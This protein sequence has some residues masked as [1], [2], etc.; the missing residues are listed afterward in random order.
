[1]TSLRIFFN[2]LLVTVLVFVVGILLGPRLQQRPPLPLAIPHG[3]V[4]HFVEPTSTA[5][6]I[7]S[8]SQDDMLDAE[9][10]SSFVAPPHAQPLKGVDLDGRLHRLGETD[11]CRASVVVFLGTECPI[12]KSV[13]PRVSRLAAE[14]QA[15]HVEFYGV[16]S[17]PSLSHQSAVEFAREYSISF[18]LL[19]DV[20]GELKE[21]LQATHTPHAFVLSPVGELLYRGA[22]DDQFVSA[23]GRRRDEPRSQWL[24]DA[25]QAVTHQQPIVIAETEP[26]GCLLEPFRDQP[27]TY[28]REIAPI[29]LRQCA[30][31]HQPGAVAPFSLLTYDDVRRH[32]A[33][34]RVMVDLKQMPPWRPLR[35][36]G[37]FRNELSLSDREI[38]LLTR[39][40]DAGLPEGDRSQQWVTA[41]KETREAN[42]SANNSTSDVAEV[43]AS[44]WLLGQ[45]DLIL[46][47]PEPFAV[48]ADGP[49]IYQYFVVPTK[50]NADR[51]VS[52]I[53]Y[54]SSNTRVVHHASFRFDDAGRARQLDLEQ[55]GLGYQRF[56]GWG[57]ETGGTLGGWA[58]GN[59]P[60][61][62]PAGF[63]RPI[64]A[65]SDF[66]LQTHYHPTGRAE[67]EQATLGVHFAPASSTRHIGEL[68]V[69]NQQL[70]IPPN[71]RRFVHRVAYELPIAVT[72]YS[73]L[74]HTHLLGRETKAVARHPDGTV[75]PLIWIDDWR[76]NWQSQYFFKQ[77]KHWPAGTRLE[78]E[79]VF[80]NS[81]ANPLNPHSVPQ[82]V[83]WGEETTQ[84]M[85][86]C[87][88][89]VA[90]DT[91]EE[92]DRL[93]AHN[94]QAQLAKLAQSSR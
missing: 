93:I 69:A 26:I 94:R 40:I 43:S 48:P 18:P 83:H 66:V 51:L 88:F 61:R 30:N 33:Q 32:A 65:G 37:S 25:L 49:D 87:F 27:L 34:I 75:E 24:R 38:S 59:F 5:P 82:W 15:Q 91:N 70:H 7:E 20:T 62:F 68:I 84:E 58:F 55:P 23:G 35:G 4:D 8:P 12:A 72:A 71:E 63:G 6:S 73:V 60:Q 13:L 78:F 81:A 19:F 64:K 67:M 47:V 50:L 31:C 11:G 57:F 42:R 80:D 17:S 85:A 76:F 54:R 90:A 10:E 52:A 89:D 77:P 29:V 45:P 36:F 9:A 79:V 16:L 56:G 74:P 41:A 3:G 46:K 39:W 44:G 86:V 21:R 1:M 53:E 14:Y 22:I 28:S 92:L 2:A